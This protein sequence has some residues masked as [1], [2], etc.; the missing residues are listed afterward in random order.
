MGITLPWTGV[1][2]KNEAA[3]CALAGNLTF[4]KI[5]FFIRVVSDSDAF[6]DIHPRS[7]ER[8]TQALG[9]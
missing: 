8:I 6:N 9:T 7:R 4:R 2:G 5:L 3:I 1:G